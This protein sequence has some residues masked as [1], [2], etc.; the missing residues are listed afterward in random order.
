MEIEL[1]EGPP[2]AG[3]VDAVA[4]ALAEPAAAVP[5]SAAAADRLLDGALGRL[6]GAGEL[7]GAWNRST[8]V[9]GD[10]VR[11]LVAGLGDPRAVDPDTIRDAAAAV[12]REGV[13]GA[14]AWFLDDSLPVPVVEQARAVVDGL[15]LGAFDPG[16]WKTAA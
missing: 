7:D 11:A 4:F 1:L 8:V 16:N 5:A 3:G 6:A 14:L 15:V 12:A 9:H 10:G 13:T 2:A